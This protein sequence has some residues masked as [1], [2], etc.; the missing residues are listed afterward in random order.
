VEW[1]I[2]V[3]GDPPVMVARTSGTASVAGFVAM[4]DAVLSHPGF[5][6]GIDLIQDLTGLA[7]YLS[8]SGIRTLADGAS[9]TAKARDYWGR[10]AIVVSGPAEFGLARMWEAYADDDLAARTRV[11]ASLDEAYD[12]LRQLPPAP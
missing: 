9:R 12:W 3:S 5:V 11:F 6:P 1:E 2:I 4:R 10:L 7:G 8:S